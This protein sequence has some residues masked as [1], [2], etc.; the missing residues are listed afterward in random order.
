MN[1]AWPRDCPANRFHLRRNCGGPSK[2]LSRITLRFAGP[3]GQESVILPFIESILPVGDRSLKENSKPRLCSGQTCVQYYSAGMDLIGTVPSLTCFEFSR[4]GCVPVYRQVFR[5]SQ[6]VDAQVYQ[7]DRFPRGP[8]IRCPW[9]NSKVQEH[10][11]VS[12]LLSL[13]HR[14]VHGNG[15]YAVWSICR[16]PIEDNDPDYSQINMQWHLRETCTQCQLSPFDSLTQ[17]YTPVSAQ[18]QW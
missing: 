9:M 2:R 5:K 8:R 14:S 7:R 4:V 15:L 10:I 6:V 1:S 3:Q 13:S 18:P 16:K 11:Y 12:V 17:Q